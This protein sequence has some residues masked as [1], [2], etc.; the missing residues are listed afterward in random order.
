V[1][2]VVVVVV[3]L[4]EVVEVEFGG[5]DVEVLVVPVTEVF[6]VVVLDVF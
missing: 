6:V 3:V 2:F 5:C 4:V 1:L